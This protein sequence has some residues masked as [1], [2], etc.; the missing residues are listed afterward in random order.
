MN[1]QKWPLEIDGLLAEDTLGKLGEEEAYTL[2]MKDFLTMPDM[3]FSE[4][5]TSDIQ[6]RVMM[7]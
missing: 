1:D 2:Y 7:N 4:I 3:N 5:A 6:I